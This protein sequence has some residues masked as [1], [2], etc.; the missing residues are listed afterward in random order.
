MSHSKF[1]K[2]K[3]ERLENLNLPFEVPAAKR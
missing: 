3:K 1:Q 2:V